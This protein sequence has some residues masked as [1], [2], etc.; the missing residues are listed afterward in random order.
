MNKLYVTNSGAVFGINETEDM[1]IR[2]ESKWLGINNAYILEEDCEIISEE[3]RVNASVGDILVTF[4]SKE[5]PNRFAILKS[6]E[7]LENNKAQESERENA[8]SMQRC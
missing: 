8:S 1:P 6:N 5:I 3:K 2:I 4:Y 7:I